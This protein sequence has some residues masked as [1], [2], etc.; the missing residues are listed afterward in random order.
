VKQ[1]FSDKKSPGRDGTFK[2]SKLEKAIKDVIEW[3]LG[4]GHAEERMFVTG[5]EAC[6]T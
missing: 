6:K 5:D 3:K 1:V 4:P 2:A